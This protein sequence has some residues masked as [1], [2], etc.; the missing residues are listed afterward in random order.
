MEKS[1]VFI[2]GANRG[3]GIEFAKQYL[4]DG[5][6]VLATYRDAGTAA[7]LKRL[8]GDIKRFCLDITNI[9][10]VQKVKEEIKDEPIDILINNAAIHG[11][12]DK[13]ATFGQIDIDSWLEVMKTN[14]FYTTK[15]T[16]ILFD[17][18]KK[19]KQKKI[20]FISSRAGSISERGNL[21]HHL[22]GGSYIYR[23]SKAALNSAAQSLAF[24]YTNQGINVI[25]LHPG[26][27]KTRMAGDEADISVEKS[28]KGMK[29]KID[30][31][32]PYM[33][34]TFYNYDGKVIAW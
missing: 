31:F 9:E 20:V 17:L 30:S 29:E 2:T 33:N 34:R 14:V 24:D 12:A 26:W 16:E 15:L 11:P 32:K 8:K 25:V 5:Y 19:G 23:S 1:T 13:S 18:I 21:P 27:V 7:E 6:K 28:V 10:E 4:R 22:H 3:I